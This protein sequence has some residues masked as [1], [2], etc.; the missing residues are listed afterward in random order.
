MF[1]LFIF[2]DSISTESLTLSPGATLILG[3]NTL[4]NP[5]AT[6]KPTESSSTQLYATFSSLLFCLCITKMYH[7]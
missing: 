3:D 1:S 5:P 7:L 4:Y 6:E 2:R